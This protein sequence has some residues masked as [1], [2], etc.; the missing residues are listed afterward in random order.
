MKLNNENS[1]YPVWRPLLSQSNAYYGILAISSSC[2]NGNRNLKITVGYNTNDTASAPSKSPSNNRNDNIGIVFSRNPSTVIRHKRF[3]STRTCGIH[4]RHPKQDIES[5][6]HA[7]A[8]VNGTL[9]KR[10]FK[11]VIIQTI[12]TIPSN[13]LVCFTFYIEI[14]IRLTLTFLK[15]KNGHHPSCVQCIRS[16]YS[17]NRK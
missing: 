10:C 7:Q 13:L 15:T 4:K 3:R 5:R 1:K 11:I 9:M 12:V 16:S 2:S 14:F 8:K 17:C 6:S